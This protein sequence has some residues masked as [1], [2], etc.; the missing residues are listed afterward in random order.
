ME[1]FY[2]PFSNNNIIFSM[3]P[4]AQNYGVC[5]DT[6]GVMRSVNEKTHPKT[7]SH[8]VRFNTGAPQNRFTQSL[9]VQSE[10]QQNLNTLRSSSQSPKLRTSS[11]Y[12]KGVVK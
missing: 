2:S 9:L 7:T 11:R 1:E 10:S 8:S 12:G 5:L 6:F 3:L 4:I